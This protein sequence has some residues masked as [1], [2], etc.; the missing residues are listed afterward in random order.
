MAT[1]MHRLQI[2]LPE[3]QAQYLAERARRDGVS[4]AEIVRRLVERE[5]TAAADP[6]SADALWELA[7]MAEDHGPLLDG[8]PVSENPELYLTGTPAGGRRR[9]PVEE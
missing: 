3:W 5:S 4:I 1:M 8:T 7:G 9:P 2:S 6:R